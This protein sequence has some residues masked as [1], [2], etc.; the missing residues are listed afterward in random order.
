MFDKKFINKIKKPDTQDDKF[1][2]LSDIKTIMKAKKIN[3]RKLNKM[4]GISEVSLS[5]LFNMHSNPNMDTLVRVAQA[6]GAKVR[7]LPEH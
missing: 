4:T 7:V 1:V 3:Q 2:I 5:L 6:V